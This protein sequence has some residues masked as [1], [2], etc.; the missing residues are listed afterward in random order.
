MPALG[1]CKYD[2]DLIRKLCDGVRSS[3]EIAA[4][5]GCSAKYVQKQM[6]KLDLPRRRRGGATGED[7]PAWISGRL[8]DLDGY[9]LVPAVEGHP[10]ARMLPGKRSGRILEHR[11]VMEKEIG[12]YLEPQE[13]VDHIDGLHLHNDPSNL[14]LFP[15]NQAHLRETISESLPEWSAAGL[16]SM[17]STR[18]QR[19]L[20]QRVDTYGLRKKRGDVRLRQILLAWLSPDIGRQHLLGTHHLLE[21]I[22][23]DWRSRSSLEQAWA[24]LSSR[25]DADLQSSE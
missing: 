11:L 21:R 6:V 1:D 7:N 25:W 10:H 18:R 9:A 14:R 17:N 22:Q 13:V 15:N 20:R 5:A 12:R 4:L 16:A 23:I 24:D 3:K 19:K 2:L 8:I